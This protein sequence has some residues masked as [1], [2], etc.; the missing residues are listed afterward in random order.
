MLNSFH[1]TSS[2]TRLGPKVHS[3][4]VEQARPLDAVPRSETWYYP[5]VIPESGKNHGVYWFSYCDLAHIMQ[6]DQAEIKRLARVHSWR[7]RRHNTT[8]ER[9]WYLYDLLASVWEYMLGWY[10]HKIDMELF[11]EAKNRR[12]NPV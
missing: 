6:I 7:S 11:N 5:Y 2:K 8:K 3:D 9:Q 12:E 4:L 1:L 10:G